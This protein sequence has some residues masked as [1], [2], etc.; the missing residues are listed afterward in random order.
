M[1]FWYLSSFRSRIYR[2]FAQD[3]YVVSIG[4]RR[5]KDLLFRRG[6][7]QHL[8]MVRFSPTGTQL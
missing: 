3:I 7:T 4:G 1:P 6:L 5:M 8:K 2:V